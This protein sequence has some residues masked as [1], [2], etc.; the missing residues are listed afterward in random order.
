MYD[1]IDARLAVAPAVAVYATLVLFRANIIGSGNS[2]PVFGSSGLRR[3]SSSVAD[4]P[5]T[6]IEYC[7]PRIS[8]STNM[9]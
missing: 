7:R 4:L 9:G 6:E 5:D 2:S 1:P 3:G 8:G